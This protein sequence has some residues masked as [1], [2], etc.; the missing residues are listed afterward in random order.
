VYRPQ[1]HQLRLPT[2]TIASFKG[3]NAKNTHRQVHY[4]GF[5]ESVSLAAFSATLSR[6]DPQDDQYRQHLR[7][8]GREKGPCRCL[9]KLGGTCLSRKYVK[10]GV[11]ADA[12]SRAGRVPHRRSEYLFAYH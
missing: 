10:G 6:G 2:L 5:P 8:E 1:L 7:P 4:R 11:V 9:T 3:D 12:L